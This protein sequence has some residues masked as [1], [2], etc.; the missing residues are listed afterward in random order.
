MYI[1]RITNEI[2]PCKKNDFYFLKHHDLLKVLWV[3]CLYYDQVTT[4]TSINTAIMSL[5]SLMGCPQQ[6]SLK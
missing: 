3:T 2:L 6:P 1:A 5:F 4:F